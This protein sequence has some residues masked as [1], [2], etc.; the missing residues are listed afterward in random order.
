M[1]VVHVV[2]SVSEEASG[3]SYSVVRLCESLIRQESEVTLATLDGG[4]SAAPPLHFVKPFPVGLG[5]GRLGRSPAMRSWLDGQVGTG[6]V[7]LIHNHSLWMLPN[8][9]PGW[10]ARKY[11]VP[12]MVSPRGTLSG[13]AFSSGSKLKGLFWLL[14][15]KAALTA[16]T[17]FHATAQS[18]Y[19][20]IRRMGFRQ[21]V[22]I[23]PNGIDISPAGQAPSSDERILLFLG[24]IHP[25][26][27]LDN[28]LRA[29]QVCEPSFSEWRLRIAGPDNDGYLPKMQALAEELRLKNVAF[30]GPLYG[31]AKHAAYREA[32]IFVLPTHSENFGMTVA[33]ALAVGTPAIVTR[34]APWSGLGPHRAGWWIDV[35]VD[36]LVACLE[37]AMSRSR[38]ELMGMG[39]SG[40]EWMKEE[41]SWVGIARK[42][43]ETY[44]WLLSGASAINRPAWVRGAGD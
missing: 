18:E 38:S 14:V 29:W 15:Q 43:L 22:C 36:P 37:E 1:K 34:G 25:V 44:H 10:T 12:L 30:C 33:E 11:G 23:I 27:G 32:D 24:R 41:F 7:S 8:V 39:Q 19:E 17:C 31:E 21:P 16:T 6:A 42:M 3:P 4:R 28:L 20:D 9:Y 5:P 2:P 40:Q 13:W 35:G 26:K